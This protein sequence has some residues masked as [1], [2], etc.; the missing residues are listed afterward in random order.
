LN[1]FF[2][3]QLPESLDCRVQLPIIVDD[4]SEPEP[5][6]AIV[7]RRDDDYQNEHP[8]PTDVT[9]LIEVADSSL[10]RDLG[11]KLRLYAKSGIQDYWVVHVERKSVIVHRN[12][13]STRYRSTETF[14]VGRTIAPA[15]VPD[16]QLDLGWLFR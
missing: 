16:C 2:V 14:E 13:V 4:H 1:Y 9:L 3:R 15:S 11:R 6:I 8:S 10:K 5:D 12:P 7:Q